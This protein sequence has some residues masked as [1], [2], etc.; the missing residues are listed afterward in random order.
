MEIRPQSATNATHAVSKHYKKIASAILIVEIR[1]LFDII[2]ITKLTIMKTKM[3]I[4]ISLVFFS[5]VLLSG[6]KNDK[7]KGAASDY[8]YIP[9]GSCSINDSAFSFDGFWISQIEVTNSSYAL[10]LTD[11]KLKGNEADLK[12]ASVQNDKWKLINYG[13]PY[14]DFYSTHKAYVDYPVVNLTYEGAL[15]YC[16]WLT[17]K[18]EDKNWE[19]RLPTKKEWIYAAKG[20]LEKAEY[21]W[22]GPYLRDAKGQMLGNFLKVGEENIHRGVTGF[23]I[24]N[25]KKLGGIINASKSYNPNEWGLYNMCGNVAEMTRE[26][27]TALGGSWNDTGYDVRIMSEKSYNEPSPIIGFRP[28]LVRKK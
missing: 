6:F 25:A 15:L 23:E 7:I 21:S 2:T 20:G 28:V 9:Q 27:G 18:L 5:F 24:I 1:S 22:G 17:S 16:K 8:S 19:Y 3:L 13:E 12:I 26:K 11:L 10:F 4:S 14:S